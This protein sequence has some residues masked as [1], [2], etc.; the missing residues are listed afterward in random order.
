MV[1]KR[2]MLFVKDLPS[3][4]RFYGDTLGLNPIPETRTDSWIEFETGF[5]LHA[6][7]P[8]IADGIEI[9]SPPRP[10]ENH[11]IKLAFAVDDLASECERLEGLGVKTIQTRWGTCDAVDPEGNIFQLCPAK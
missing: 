8:H 1:L 10:R 3:M 4:A 2:A 11:P 7:P 9:L 5:A 6:I